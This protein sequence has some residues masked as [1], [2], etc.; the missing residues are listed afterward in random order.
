MKPLYHLFVLFW[1]LSGF[2]WS[3]KPDPWTKSIE[4]SGAIDVEKAVLDFLNELLTKHPNLAKQVEGL[5]ATARENAGGRFSY[6]DPQVIEW[7]VGMKEVDF[8]ENSGRDH[9]TNTYLIIRPFIEGQRK[10]YS[11]N[12]KA[13]AK[14]E[15]DSV[16]TFGSNHSKPVSTRL[17]ITFKG[18]INLSEFPLPLPPVEPS[19]PPAK[20]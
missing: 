5:S 13:I 2:A 3:E 16:Q 10:G 15:T 14:M 17:R 9:T 11:V 4:Q 18:F 20:K 19:E 8:K 12:Q 1:L 6:G 7:H